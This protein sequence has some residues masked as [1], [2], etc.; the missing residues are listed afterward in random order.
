MYCIDLDCFCEIVF[1]LL[2]VIELFVYYEFICMVDLIGFGDYI[3]SGQVILVE[4]N[5]QVGGYMFVMYFDDYL[6]IVGGCELWGFLKKFVLFMLY[7]NIDYILGMFDYGKVCVVIG[8]MGYKYKEFDIDEQMK[9]F[10]GFNFLLKIILYVDGIVCVCELVCYYMQ[11]IKMKGVWMG[12]V[13]LEL[14]LYVFVLVVDLLVFEIVEVCYFVV[15]LMLG[16]GEV[17]YDYLVQ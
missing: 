11:D 2:Q 6:L 13:L 1:E 14:V 9:W 4:Y 12:F 8:M 3:E 10:V 15:D 16:F 5:G 7:V 17:V